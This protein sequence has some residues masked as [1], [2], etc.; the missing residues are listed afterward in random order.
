MNANCGFSCSNIHDIKDKKW[1]FTADTES[2]CDNNVE[3]EEHEKLS[4]GEAHTVRYPGTVVV[5]VKYA[6]LAC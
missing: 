4:V 3:K 2:K 1:N 5:H 6:S